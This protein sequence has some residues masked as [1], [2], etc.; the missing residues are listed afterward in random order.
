VTIGYYRTPRR[1]SS[2]AGLPAAEPEPSRRPS[3][4]VRPFPAW[5]AGMP[6]MCGCVRPSFVARLRWCRSPVVLDCRTCRR[7]GRG[8]GQSPVS[9]C[10]RRGAG[11]Q[12]RSRRRCGSRCC[13]RRRH[14]DD[15]RRTDVSRGRANKTRG[16]LTPGNVRVTLPKFYARGVRARVGWPRERVGARAILHHRFHSLW[17]ARSLYGG[18]GFRARY[19]DWR[20]N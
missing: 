17:E 12:P 7:K 3:F 9:C 8:A 11:A 15:G 5:R 16:S 1:G 4:H 18:S 19:G 13:P 6:V 10:R 14:R 20:V 2:F